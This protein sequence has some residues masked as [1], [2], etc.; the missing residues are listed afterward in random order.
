MKFIPLPSAE[1][2]RRIFT[3]DKDTGVVSAR[4]KRPRVPAGSQ[5]GNLHHGYFRVSINYQLYQLHRVIWC[6]VTGNDPGDFE[7]DHEDGNRTNNK[8]V[9]LRL[10]TTS[11]NQQNKNIQSN[12]KSGIK[13][14]CWDKRYSMWRATIKLSSKSKHLGYFR[15]KE[16]AGEAIRK[17]REELHKEFTNHG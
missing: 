8:W 13:G 6:M 7:V 5:I 1:Q 2:L 11:G 16:L 12:N 14:V 3:Y 4:V 9:N 15:D 10:A 17:A